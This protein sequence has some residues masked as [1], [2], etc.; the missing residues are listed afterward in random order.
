MSNKSTKSDSS[1]IR[2]SLWKRRS[3]STVAAFVDVDR[4]ISKKKQGRSQARIKTQLFARLSTFDCSLAISEAALGPPPHY[5]HQ[6][7]WPPTFV[8]HEAADKL[9]D[10]DGGLHDGV[11]QVVVEPG[12]GHVLGIAGHVNDTT[13]VEQVDRQVR[14]RQVGLR[15]TIRIPKA[16]CQDRRNRH[17]V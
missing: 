16:H 1:S 3:S 7:W 5:V 14:Q 12:H 13:R 15:R 8:A 4:A 11:E 10:P 17:L 9:F 2:E 6:R